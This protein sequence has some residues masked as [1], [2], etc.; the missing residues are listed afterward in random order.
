MPSN[1]PA[2]QAAF[3]NPTLPE[4]GKALPAPHV[5]PGAQHAPAVPMIFLQLPGKIIYCTALSA[6][7]ELLDAHFPPPSSPALQHSRCF[8]PLYLPP[9]FPP[10]QSVALRFV[11][12]PGDPESSAKEKQPICVTAKIYPWRLQRQPGERRDLSRHV[13]GVVIHQPRAMGWDL[14]AG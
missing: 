11:L 9:P 4:W 12:A 2:P 14:S 5:P 10:P 1:L 7:R 3:I 6:P 8:S 13:R